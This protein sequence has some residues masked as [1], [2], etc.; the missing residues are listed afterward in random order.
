MVYDLIHINY[1]T[2]LLVMF[3][4][5]FL[6]SNVSFERRIVKMF[7]ISIM[8][9][10]VLV[11][12]DSIE[13][14]TESLS[15]PT[16]LRV[17]MSAIGYT[18]RPLGIFCVL[19]IITDYRGIKR[20]FLA[21]PAIINGLIAFSALF[22][23]IAFS[24]SET[25]EFE[26]GPLGFATYVTGAIYLILLCIE[27]VKFIQQKDYYE[28]LVVFAIAFINVLSIFLEAVYKFDGFINASIAV[29]VTF[30]YMYYHAQNFK[31]DALTRVLNRRTYEVDLERDSK[32]V[33][34]MISLDLN[35]LK[36]INDTQGHIAGD[37]ALVTVAK[38]VRDNMISGCRF[39]RTGGDEFEILY[40]KDNV[41][42]LDSMIDGIRMDIEKNS[43]SCAIGKAVLKDNETIEEL[44]AR[45][46]AL[47]YE[48]KK[49][50][51][52]IK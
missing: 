13:T 26:R 36:A 18:V 42:K 25:N 28:A 38:C 41:E 14:Y 51:K 9:A 45:A 47:M 24:Y 35:F 32:E 23:D 52:G 12:V 27:T 10:L 2:I 22:T 11:I 30:Y 43:Y 31:R 4:I 49:R 34:A 17:W 19:I 48:D 46:D 50:I 16:M 7:M 1:T 21:L 44:T 40:F 6:L 3:M 5:V 29:S 33:S 39:Y 15:Y 20:L 37:K 8:T